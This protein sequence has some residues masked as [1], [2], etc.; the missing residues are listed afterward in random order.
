MR[1]RK[2]SLRLGG[3]DYSQAGYYFITICTQGKAK[4]FGTLEHGTMTLSPFGHIVRHC[5]RDLAKHYH[6]R[7]DAFIIMPDHIHGIIILK[8]NPHLRAD[9]LQKQ[10][11]AASVRAD[12]KPAPTLPPDPTLPRAPALGAAPTLPPA[13]RR[14]TH[15]LSEIIR[16]F[17]TFSARRINSLRHSTGFPLWQRGYY[18]H[19]IRTEQALGNIRNY[20]RR[21]PQAAASRK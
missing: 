14:A 7:L 15:P 9:R 4:L 5:W 11:R 6:C 21:N 10:G 2:N 1:R 17:K 8:D 12:F 19:I 20:I 3:W 18:D 13:P 16:G